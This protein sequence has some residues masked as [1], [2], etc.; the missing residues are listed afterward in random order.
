MPGGTHDGFD[1][2]QLS[3]AD[4][5][6]YARILRLEALALNAMGNAYSALKAEADYDEARIWGCIGRGG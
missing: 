4:Q 5:H 6:E 3:A 1:G 2:Q